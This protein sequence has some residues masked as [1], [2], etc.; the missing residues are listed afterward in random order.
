MAYTLRSLAVISSVC[1]ILPNNM[2]CVLAVALT[3]LPYWYDGI[4][5]AYDISHSNFKYLFLQFQSYGLSAR[6]AII[7]FVS[8]WKN[9]SLICFLYEKLLVQLFSIRENNRWRILSE[10]NSTL[11]TFPHKKLIVDDFL[12]ENIIV[13]DFYI[14]K[15]YFWKIRTAIRCSNFL[16]KA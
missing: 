8:L 4:W 6:I 1:N 13:V 16:W 11:M 5:K 10:K 2:N 9:I 14:L 12:Y 7:L 15:A 3:S